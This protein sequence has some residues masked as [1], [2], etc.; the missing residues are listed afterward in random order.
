MAKFMLSAF[1]DEASKTLE[2]QIAALERNH[3]SYIEPRDIDGGILTKTNDE[4]ADIRARLDD[5]GIKVYSLGSPIGKY[6]VELPFQPHWEKFLRALEICNLLGAKY[7][8]I[9]SF[10]TPQEELTQRRETV[11][12]RLRL[13]T[14][15]AKADGITLCHENESKIYGQNPAQVRDILTHIP[16]LMGVFD[17]AN[18]IMNQQ[19]PI[20]GFEA[21]REKLQYI[22]VKDAIAKYQTTI[23]VGNGEGRYDEILKKVDAMTDGIV[24]LTLEPHLFGFKA[25]K[26]IDSHELKTAVKYE[27]ADQAFD[28]AATALRNLLASLG[29][30]EENFVWTK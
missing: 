7:M 15:R 13:M 20:E 4:L 10:F 25:Y 14:E 30:H 6:K 12:S 21:T 28:A 18:L 5:H 11:L 19:D 8:R 1:A 17:A 24:T 2:G 23:A 27:S 22:H 26:N 16:G 9:F 3:F 29:Y